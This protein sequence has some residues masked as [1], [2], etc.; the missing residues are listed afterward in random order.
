M[1]IIAITP[2]NKTDYLAETVIDGL[3]TLGF[4]IIATDYG[5]GV[6]NIYSDNEV[7]EHAKDADFIFAIWGKVRGNRPPKFYLL[8][9]INK[10]EK[11]VYIDG[12]EWTYTGNPNSGQTYRA[13]V[14][15]DDSARREEPWVNIDMLKN[16]KF[17]FKRECYPED[18]KLGI[19]PLLFGANTDYFMPI[20]E[21]SIDLFCAFGQDKDGLRKEAI[22][23]S[24]KARDMGYKVVVKNNMPRQEYLDTLSKSRMSIDAWGGGDCCKRLWEN[25]AAKTCCLMQDYR[26]EFPDSFTDRL[27]ILK[28]SDETSLKDK[29]FWALEN[30]EATRAIADKGY[31]HL[32]EK[33]TSAKRVEYIFDILRKNK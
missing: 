9:Y 30:P 7:L 6:E 33:H 31:N 16:S 17:Y 25:L 29:L 11:T 8:D 19:Y 4:K 13:Q 15:K 26:V 24:K 28:Y 10:P 3:K 2:N 32:L 1:K 5:N 23:Y 27:N 22:Y 12:S 20:K 14:L 21:K 18:L